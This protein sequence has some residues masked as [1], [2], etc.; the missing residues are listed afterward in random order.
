MTIQSR[1]QVGDDS[2]V[3]GCREVESLIWV[4]TTQLHTG[5]LEQQ[6]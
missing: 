6:C 2:K 3:L 4:E 1:P 5:L